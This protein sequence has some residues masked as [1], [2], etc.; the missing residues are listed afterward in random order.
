MAFALNALNML[1]LSYHNFDNHEFS[2]TQYF[3]LSTALTI[4][5]LFAYYYLY[6][7]FN[8]EQDYEYNDITLQV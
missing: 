2:A 3:M 4:N 5:T 8:A 1:G 7:D 6:K